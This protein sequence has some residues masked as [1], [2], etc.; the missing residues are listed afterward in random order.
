MKQDR[1]LNFGYHKKRDATF[2]QKMFFQPKYKRNFY[3]FVL[4]IIS[5]IFLIFGLVY[6]FN[7]LKI[8]GI[9]FICL[10]VIS[11]LWVDVFARSSLIEERKVCA[12]SLFFQKKK[13]NERNVLNC[14]ENKLKI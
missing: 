12:L 4:F 14:I 5:L 2:R 6:D 13:Q 1:K 9:V 10:S 3:A 8:T 7:E 11:F